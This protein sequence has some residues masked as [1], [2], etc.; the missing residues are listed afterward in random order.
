MNIE[1]K[2]ITKNLFP[3]AEP[4]T[5]AA[6]YPRKIQVP[7]G[8]ASPRYFATFLRSELGVACHPELHALPHWTHALNVCKQLELGVPTYFVRSEFAQAVTQT[9][10]PL[11]FKFSEILWPLDAMLFVMPDVFALNYFGYHVPF[12]S[13]CRASAGL[14][15]DCVKLPPLNF[16]RSCFTKLDNQTDRFVVVGPC[17][18]RSDTFVDYTGVFN[19]TQT[20]A[21]VET[22][23][24]NDATYYEEQLFNLK[25]S[26]GPDL[27]SGEAEKVFHAKF[28]LFA[29]KLMLALT[30]RP[31]LIQNGVQTRKETVLKARHPRIREALWSPNTVGWEYRAAR[32]LT[33]PGADTHAS[34]RLH[35]RRGHWTHQPYG[36]KM[37]LRKLLWL[38]P[39]LVNAPPA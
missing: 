18:S 29:V 5:Y 37:S 35:W 17:Y 31:G 25:P 27:P 11:D 9:N 6:C 32:N 38:E 20:I 15:P 36:E 1:L 10:P 24:F 19:M 34:P 4:I 28:I 7:N 39:I 13:V 2:H 3:Q 33:A 14:Y 12:I 22:C 8:F 30:A 23:K 21:E 16:P 26:T